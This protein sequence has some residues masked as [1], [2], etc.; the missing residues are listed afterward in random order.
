MPS[1]LTSLRQL[2]ARLVDRLVAADPARSRLR[3]AA[4]ALLALVL[5]TAVLFGTARFQPLPIAAYGLGILLSFI[6]TIG[7]R[8]PGWRRQTATRALAGLIGAVA[9]VLAGALAR[10]PLVAD[11]GF[12]V[13]I[14]VSVYIR[15][16]GMRWLAVGMVAFMAYFMGEYMRPAPVDAGFVLFAAAVALGSAQLASAVLFP[17]DPEQDFRRA[18]RTIDRRINLILDHL[19]Q[20]AR[21]GAL[22][23]DDRRT[24][25]A[26]MVE[27][28]EIVL[29]AEGFV[30]QITGSGLALTG[31][32]AELAAG[33][34]DLLLAVERLVRYRE[35]AL[36]PA[37]ALLALLEERGPQVRAGVARPD[38][39][40]TGA[41]DQLLE[42]VRLARGRINAALG[43][44]PSPAF[45]GIGAPVPAARQ[46][47]LG[48]PRAGVPA[49]FHRPIQ[50]TLACGLALAA[51]LALSPTRWYWAVI[52]SYIV[53]NNTRTRAD[54]AVRALNRSAGTLGGV[55]AGTLLATLL[56]GHA[57]A[58]GLLIPAVFFLAVYNLQTSYGWMIFFFTIGLALLYGLMGMFTPELLL[59]RL[60]ETVVGGLCGVGAAFLIFPVHTGGE[61][62]TAL[63]EFLDALGALVGAAAARAAGED[64]NLTGA[65]LRLDRSYGALATAVRP[66]GGPWSVVTRFGSVRAKLLLLVS[67]A[68]WARVLASAMATE[69]TMGAAERARVADLVAGVD[70]KI[71]RL[72]LAAARWFAT[73]QTPERGFAATPS[74]G[75]LKRDAAIGALETIDDL[76][77]RAVAQLGTG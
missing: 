19:L 61:V 69:A 63:A 75:E 71:A 67:C 33:L 23:P 66:L 50:V 37:A 54:T 73:G 26:Q 62:E 38:A 70:D 40:A 18:L 15:R 22:P 2:L 39:P 68:H 34:V 57:M 59:L 13:V 6:G 76:L 74:A 46:A 11:L 25:R 10:W 32:A 4:R 47:A 44:S 3:L 24:I 55:L 41:A 28:R 36:P 56:Q 53:F 21:A 60:V 64:S 5:T 51:G 7:V 1:A 16:Y 14:F 29:M 42:A 58:S 43:P 49:A 9:A 31:A 27:F 77:G 30:P 45:A 35:T 52:T 20:A 65:S 48:G 17:D 72:R 12:L 8:E